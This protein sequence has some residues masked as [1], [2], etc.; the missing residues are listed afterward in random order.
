MAVKH[1]HERGGA[2]RGRCSITQ[3]QLRYYYGTDNIDAALVR[4]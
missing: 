1:L 3:D 4:S 2:G